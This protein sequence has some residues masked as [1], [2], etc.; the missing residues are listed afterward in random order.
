[1]LPVHPFYDAL[2]GNERKEVS[3][4]GSIG[5]EVQEGEIVSVPQPGSGN[6]RRGREKSS[7]NAEAVF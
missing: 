1:M 3:D 4:N 5:A 6:L 7:A 2:L